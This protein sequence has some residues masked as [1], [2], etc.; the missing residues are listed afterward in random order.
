[1][2]GPRWGS[3]QPIKRQ[4]LTCCTCIAVDLNSFITAQ[5][6]TRSTSNKSNW[7]TADRARRINGSIKPCGRQYSTAHGLELEALQCLIM[8]RRNCV[9]ESIQKCAF[10]TTQSICRIRWGGCGRAV[11]LLG[12]VRC[13]KVSQAINSTCASNH[14]ELAWRD[15]GDW[16]NRW[17]GWCAESSFS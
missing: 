10:V 15:G 17:D 6:K 7:I 5:R 9:S 8:V 2:Y 12:I 1:M 11:I 14:C 16:M 3:W 4:L 13:Y